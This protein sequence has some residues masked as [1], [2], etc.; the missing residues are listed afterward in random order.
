MIKNTLQQ[1]GNNQVT[2]K[3]IPGLNRLFLHCN[4]CTNEEIPQLKGDFAPEAWQEIK[5]W[6]QLFL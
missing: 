2:V 1:S 4:T 5:R 3:V 6:L